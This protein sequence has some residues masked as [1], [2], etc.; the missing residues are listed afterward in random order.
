MKNLYLIVIVSAIAYTFFYSYSIQKNKVLDVVLKDIEAIATPETDGGDEDKEKI[1]RYST[2]PEREC[3][4]LVGGA[5]AKGKKVVCYSG[6]EHP[7]CVDC[8]L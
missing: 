5:Y 2:F 1:Y 7:V 4:I 3:M 8:Q 6:N